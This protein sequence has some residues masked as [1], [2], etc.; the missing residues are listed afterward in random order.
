MSK[1]FVVAIMVRRK[2]IA[3]H[4]IYLD[5]LARPSAEEYWSKY[6]YRYDFILEV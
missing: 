1:N 2:R 5:K 4:A 6:L 3:E